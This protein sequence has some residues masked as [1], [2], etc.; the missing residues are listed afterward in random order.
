MFERLQNREGIIELFEPIEPF[1][2]LSKPNNLL[3]A[4]LYIHEQSIQH[5]NRSIVEDQH[6]RSLGFF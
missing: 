3:N 2:L 4:L 1:K 6:G 5:Q